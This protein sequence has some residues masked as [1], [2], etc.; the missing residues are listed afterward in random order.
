M[1]V[2]QTELRSKYCRLERE[3]EAFR[4]EVESTLE[5]IEDAVT[6]YFKTGQKVDRSSENSCNTSERVVR[7]V[8]M[9]LL[10]DASKVQIVFILLSSKGCDASHE[11]C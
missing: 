8:R 9:L 6:R 5:V 1:F 7:A 11:C 2:V 4:E 10:V 3:N